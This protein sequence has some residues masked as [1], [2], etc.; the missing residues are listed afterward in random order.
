MLK[1]AVIGLGLIG[2]SI[3]K[4][5]SQSDW[6]IA[7]ISKSSY[8]KAKSFTPYA[9]DMIEDVRG[10]DVVFVCSPMNEAKNVLKR[11]EGIVSPKCIVCD[12]CSLKG[13][14]EG[15]YK[16]NYIGTH[17]MAGTEESG[18]DASKDDLFQGAKWVI[19]KHNAILEEVIKF[20]G[21]TP[22]LMDAKDH[23]AAAAQISHMPMLLSFA[24]LDSV[25]SDS[26]KIIAASGFRDMTRLALTN[27]VLA[28]DMLK[29]NK[30]N[31]DKSID[32][33]IKSLTYLKNLNDDE[34]IEVLKNI[35]QKRA[36]MYDK[37]G[38][39]K[40]TPELD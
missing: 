1:I 38:K 15:N 37:K 22:V 29:M 4:S 20:M 6:E 2:G 30:K 28:Y 27:E 3:L 34:R 9:S 23:D 19:T 17:P 36:L 35:S 18:F 16:F 14:L 7:A 13:F 8:D 10:A 40:F 33:F 5:L 24:L 26:A 21:A 39:N 32:L 31:I 25:R 12:V 11:L